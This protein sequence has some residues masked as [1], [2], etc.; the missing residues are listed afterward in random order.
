MGKL[1]TSYG[2]ATGKQS[3]VMNLGPHKLARYT[4]DTVTA[5]TS[6]AYK[7]LMSIAKTHSVT[8]THLMLNVVYVLLYRVVLEVRTTQSFRSISVFATLTKTKI[9]LNGSLLCCDNTVLLVH[10]LI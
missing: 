6:S 3:G 4:T 5:A 7:K 10:R 1:P 9:M 2:L 8:H